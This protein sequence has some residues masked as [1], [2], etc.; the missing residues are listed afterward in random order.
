M[1]KN[2]KDKD[3]VKDKGKKK[4][5]S[6]SPEDIRLL[7][8]TASNNITTKKGD[9]KKAVWIKK[10]QLAYELEL[11]QLQVELMKM[12][13]SMKSKGQ[14]AFSSLRA[15]MLLEKVEQSNGLP[16]ISIRGTLGWWLSR[17]QTKPS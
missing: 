10:E 11:K 6:K 16:S 14:R 9:G 1:A 2:E 7:E 17:N 15:A 8:G 3:K 5:D 13:I 12:Q 4:K